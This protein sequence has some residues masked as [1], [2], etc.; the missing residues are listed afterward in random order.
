LVGVCCSNSV[1]HTKYSKVKVNFLTF[2]GKTV[3]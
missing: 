3:L 1:H 2:K